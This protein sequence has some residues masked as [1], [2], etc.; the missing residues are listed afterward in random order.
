LLGQQT[1]LFSTIINEKFALGVII[2]SKLMAKHLMEDAVLLYNMSI[3][4]LSLNYNIP[5]GVYKKSLASE[6]EARDN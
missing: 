2:K 5:N 6:C 4:H 1:F 3:P